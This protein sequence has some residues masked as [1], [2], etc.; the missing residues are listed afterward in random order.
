MAFSLATLPAERLKF[1]AVL[2]LQI[3]IH[4]L[5]INGLALEVGG[6]TRV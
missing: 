3:V 2:R 5:E 4:Q 1:R 6:A